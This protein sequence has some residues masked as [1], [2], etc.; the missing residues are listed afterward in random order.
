MR[1][2]VLA[3]MHQKKKIQAAYKEAIK[4]YHPDKLSHLGEEF[5]ILANEKF[6]EIQNAYDILMKK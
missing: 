4:K 6:I 5:S 2:L 3:P 1:F